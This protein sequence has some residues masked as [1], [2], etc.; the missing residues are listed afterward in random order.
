MLPRLP[1]WRPTPPAWRRCGGA[2]ASACCRCAPAGRQAPSCL[3]MAPFRRDGQLFALPGRA[4]TGLVCPACP[5]EWA[6]E[7]KDWAVPWQGRCQLPAAVFPGWRGGGLCRRCRR[8]KEKRHAAHTHKMSAAASRALRDRQARAVTR[9]APLA[10][11]PHPPLPPTPPAAPPW[12]QSP[13][14]DAPTFVRQLEGVYHR[15]WWRW[16]EDQRA[17]G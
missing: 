8:S 16:L 11:F 6:G 13:L 10:P 17:Q 4:C 2:C 5:P 15:L 1:G 9:P 12:P 14:C 3:L 7:G